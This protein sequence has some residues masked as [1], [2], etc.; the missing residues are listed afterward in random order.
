M[1]KH[2]S[3]IIFSSLALIITGCESSTS[4]TTP[5]STQQTA[6]E[7]ATLNDRMI[8][9]S[10]RMDQYLEAGEKDFKELENLHTDFVPILR[11]Q[12]YQGDKTYQ[13]DALSV[14]MIVHELENVEGAEYQS[15]L[16]T[17]KPAYEKFQAIYVKD[18]SS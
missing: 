5:V 12:A 8:V 14:G 15:L 4:D 16:E 7:P 11:W 18:S 2:L 6:Q 10:N 3:I 13:A 17:L 9:F 1:K